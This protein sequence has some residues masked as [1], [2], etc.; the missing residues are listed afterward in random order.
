MCDNEFQAHQMKKKTNTYTIISQ[1]PA[2]SCLAC[3]MAA[4]AEALSA[5]VSGWAGLPR[6][7]LLDILLRIPQDD[8]LCG[9]G[10][11]CSAWWRYSLNE[12][13]LWRRIDVTLPADL[14]LAANAARD[15][16]IRKHWK[17]MGRAAVD[18][19]AG[20]CEAFFGRADNGV[21]LYLAQR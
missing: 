7:I 18:R 16:T 21:L 15:Y 10:L 8:V 20:L 17:R 3:I 13:V 4:S 14:T 9:A 11:V 1:L 5:A 2:T 6:E 12:P 19:S